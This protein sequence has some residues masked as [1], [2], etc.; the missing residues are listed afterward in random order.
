MFFSPRINVFL[1]VDSCFPESG[2]IRIY[3]SA[4]SYI[5]DAENISLSNRI[6]TDDILMNTIG[7]VISTTS[8][9]ISRIVI[10]IKLEK[11]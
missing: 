8:F 1:P 2:I 10:K 7:L 5:P 9:L 11:T 4:D 6:M 3:T